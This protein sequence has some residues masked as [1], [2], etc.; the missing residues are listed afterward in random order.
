MKAAPRNRTLAGSTFSVLTNNIATFV[1]MALTNVLISRALGPGQRGVQAIVLLLASNSMTVVDLGLRSAIQYNL[2]RSKE[3]GRAFGEALAVCGVLMLG[4]TVLGALLFIGLFSLGRHGFLQGVSPLLLGLGFIYFLLILAQDLAV[5]LLISLRDF[6]GRNSALFVNSVVGLCGMV[7]VFLWKMKVD[8]LLVVTLQGAGVGASLIVASRRLIRAFPEGASRAYPNDWWNGYLKFG[9]KSSLSLIM[10]QANARLDS[11]VVNGILGNLPVGLYMA[12][13]SLAELSQYVNN[14]AMVVLYPETARREGADR[15]RTSLLGAGIS[16]Y[17][18]VACSIGMAFL[19]PW[20]LPLLYGRAFASA[21][22]A[23]LW[24][25]PG[26]PAMALFRMFGSVATAMGHP[27]LRAY[28]AFCGMVVTISLDLFLIPTFGIVGAAWASTLAY[29]IS[30]VIMVIL[31]MRHGNVNCRDS[32]NGIF[33]EPLRLV[34]AR[35]SA[36]NR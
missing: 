2:T 3:P 17:G 24:L 10:T 15:T 14:A 9:L 19:I 8:V 13:V 1:L 25:L 23:A 30:A 6:A 26:M 35:V 11:F 22:P 21:V 32:F 18:V 28:A 33:F 31:T 36:R 20:L 16:F 5:I 12:G 34:A 7:I 29:I 27:E 4:A